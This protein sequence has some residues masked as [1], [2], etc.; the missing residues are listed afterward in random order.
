[1]A[2]KDTIADARERFKLSH[3]AEAENREWQLDD[4]MFARMGEQWPLHVRKQR[5]LDGRPC[6]TINR[7]PAFARQ[8]VNDARQNKPAIRIRP[9]DSKADPKTAEVFTGLI[10]NIEQSSNADVAYDTALESAVY[11]G[12]G[13]FRIDTDYAH[14]DTFDL[15]I[16]IKRVANPF[17]VYGDPLS[18]AADASDWRFGFVTEMLSTEDFHSR[19]GKETQASDWSADGDDKDSLW[20]TEDSVRIAEYWEREEYTK[21]IVALSNGQVIIADQYKQHQDLWLA[22]GVVV[23]GERDT[24][25]YRVTQS[26]MTGTE[27]LEKNNWPGKYIP[28]VPVYGDEVNVQG[29]RY[30]RSLIRDARDSQMMFNFW[31]TAST[32]LVALAP[33]APFI[34]PRGAFDGDPRWQSANTKSHPYLEYEGGVPPQRQPFA[35]VPAGALQEAL[36]S[37]DDMKSILGIYDASLGARSNETSG[38]AIMARQREGDVSTFHFIDNLSRAIKYAGRC[39]IDL[40]PAVYNKPRM[41]RV[42]GEDGGVRNVAVNGQPDEY[43]QVYE[44]ARG[45]YDLVV[46]TGPSFTSKREEASNFLLETIRANPA[47]SPLLMDVAVRNMDFPEAEKVAKRFAAMLPPAIQKIE[48]QEGA[49]QEVIANQLAQAQMQ[50]QQ[51]QEALQ[52]A[53]MQAQQLEAQKVQQTGQIAAQKMQLEQQISAQDGQIAA[54]KMQLEQQIAAQSDELDRYKAN[55]DA[56]VR[57]YIEQMKQGHDEQSQLRQFAAEDRRL[58]ADMPADD[59]GTA[60]ALQDLAAGMQAMQASLAQQVAGLAS[61]ISAPKRV[62]RDPATNKVV[63]VESVLL[64]QPA[65]QQPIQ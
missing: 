22:Q 46:D 15:D 24:K 6:L 64:E 58:S 52:S 40:I 39:L 48:G 57:V 9:A 20:H 28:L 18:Q 12:V 50:I 37:S 23:T 42:L 47:T 21:P 35:G 19:Y 30:F 59:P 38:R 32:E 60:G 62:L 7:L 10:R 14:E 4:L 31:R 55:L 41:L 34:G 53:Q 27:V 16:L 63:G 13:Y 11:T 2:D 5:E 56:Q 51:M 45:K 29:K 25:C 61:V 1:M 54:Q 43:G 17:T 49:P 44:L 8:V 36:N 65:N 33:K 26:L 3:D